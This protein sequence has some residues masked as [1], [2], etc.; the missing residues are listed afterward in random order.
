MS[1]QEVQCC[2]FCHICQ[3]DIF[4]PYSAVESWMLYHLNGQ[5][6]A[7][8]CVNKFTKSVGGWTTGGLIPPY[9][10]QSAATFVKS[11][12]FFGPSLSVGAQ[13]KSL[14]WGDFDSKKTHIYLILHVF[15]LDTISHYHSCVLVFADP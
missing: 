14:F 13:N 7:C 2:I 1:P 10:R 8:K 5:L 9:F 6:F 12:E 15:Y 11:N 3:P 4:H